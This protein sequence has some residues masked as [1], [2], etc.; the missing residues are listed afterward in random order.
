MAG[1]PRV[2]EAYDLVVVGGGHAGLQA[3]LKAALLHQSAVVL[4][5]GP[6]YG[7][8]YYVPKMDNIPGFPDGISGHKLLDLQI[9]AIR[10]VADRATYVTPATVTAARRL[11]G[12]FEVTY[13]WLRQT[14]TVRGKGLVLSMGVID[15]MPSVA[16]KIDAIFPWA[17][18]ALVD[19]CMLC[20]G[21][22]F[23]GLRL[24][25]IGHD[26]FAARTALDALHFAPASVEILTYGAPFLADEAPA[27]AAEL[28][29]RLAA[30]Q[31]PVVTGEV[32]G[33][34]GL[35]EKKFEVRFSD[36][37]SRR[38]DKGFSALGWWEMHHALPT[39]LGASYDAEGFVRIDDDSRVLDA[40]GRP[41]PGLYCAGDL[42][43]RWNQIP[44]AWAA[45]ERAV[46]H[47][48]AE[49]L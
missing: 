49:Y 2:A 24:A 3:G 28:T 22:T 15:R 38:Y 30:A 31:I 17:N 21:H 25:V 6:K 32:V 26:A 20:D 19:F 16:G 36:G 46:I 29:E 10:K 44:E 1:M 37:S 5:R 12:G 11:D 43:D 47:A 14:R 33:Y 9:A 18:F 7:R 35:R 41:I 8:S 27:V 4:D 23:G 39:A 34:D 45:A 48:Y 13:E 42:A 40:D